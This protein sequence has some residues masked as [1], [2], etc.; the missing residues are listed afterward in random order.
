VPFTTNTTRS[1]RAETPHARCTD[2]V[3]VRVNNSWMLES[4]VLLRLHPL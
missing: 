4:K 2:P 3:S 1:V